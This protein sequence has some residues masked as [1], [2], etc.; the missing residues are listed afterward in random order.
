LKYHG[1]SETTQVL[2]VSGIRSTSNHKQEEM[3][4]TLDES[5]PNDK[6][7]LS[8]ILLD[9]IDKN[10]P[11]YLPVVYNDTK[12]KSELILQLSIDKPHI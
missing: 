12:Q 7:V 10:T 6:T 11:F 1:K 9:I 4:I 3:I 5:S 8:A 2:T